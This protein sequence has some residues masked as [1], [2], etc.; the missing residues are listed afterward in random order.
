MQCRLLTCGLP[1]QA[2]SRGLKWLTRQ[3]AALCFVAMEKV[4]TNAAVL[5]HIGSLLHDLHQCV[6][7]QMCVEVVMQFAPYRLHAAS[8]TAAIS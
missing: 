6:I 3:H 5:L 7:V 1:L 8:K 4:C 2:A